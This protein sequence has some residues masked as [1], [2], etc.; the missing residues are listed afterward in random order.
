MRS[1]GHADDR[2]STTRRVAQNAGSGR[3]FEEAENVAD[4]DLGPVDVTEHK[5]DPSGPAFYI[6]HVRQPDP[7]DLQA[8]RRCAMSFAVRS[9]PTD[10][11]RLL[12]APGL[13][14]GESTMNS[15]ARRMFELVEPIGV[16]P[17]SADE[18]NEAMFALGFTNYWD[19]YFAGR[20]A[21]LGLA[22]AEVVD[23]LF[24]NFAPGEVA[25][26][27]PK[28]WRTTTPEAAIAARQMGCVKALRRILGDHVDSHAF[29][30]AADLLLKAATSAPFEGRPMYA[31]LRAIPIPDD[32]VARLFHAASLL[33]EHRGD[34]HIA[35]LMIEGV[36]GLEAHVLFALD[37]G[38]PAEKFGRIHHLPAAQLAAVIDGMRDRG[39]IGD[40]GCL[41][42]PGRAVKQRIEVLTDDLAATPY[43]SLEPGELDELMAALEPLATRLLAAQDW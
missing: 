20:A 29:A 36:G 25:R 24:Y 37:M 1:C 22:P 19:T 38:M 2:A 12:A 16:I 40:D 10:R 39:L 11:E 30:R 6:D 23:A 31:A 26:H 3:A 42:E 33:R 13:Q 17:Y 35:A 41:S 21:P 18:P 14:K 34:G 43:E 8:N 15:M 7:R 4:R 9:R 32:V 27:I 28:V 5:R